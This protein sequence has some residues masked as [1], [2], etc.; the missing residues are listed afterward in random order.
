M[1]EIKFR[2]WHPVALDYYY[3]DDY[4]NLADFFE[5]IVKLGYDD[6]EMVL[7]EYTGLKDANE[8]EIWEGDV[9]RSNMAV[10]ITVAVAFDRGKF[11]FQHNQSFAP[12]SF[13]PPHL[14]EVI[15]NIYENGDLL[16]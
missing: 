12:L 8:T 9:V 15:G 3:S 16:E 10:P 5:Q 13:L 7:G 2:A 6:I 11:G 1:R 14:T 4:C